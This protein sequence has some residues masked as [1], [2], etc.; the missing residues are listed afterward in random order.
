MDKRQFSIKYN[1]EEFIFIYNEYFSSFHA[2][3]TLKETDAHSRCYK[4]DGPNHRVSDCLLGMRHSEVLVPSPEE[5]LHV[6]DV[7]SIG[8]IA[9]YC[10]GNKNSGDENSAPT[11]FLK[12]L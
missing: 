7:S 10:Q 11:S 6:I 4:C 12:I 1:F 5:P 8:H 9:R 3:C 2:Q